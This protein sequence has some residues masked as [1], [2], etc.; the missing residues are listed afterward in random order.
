MCR[1]QIRGDAF[2]RAP[3]RIA[4][5]SV[6]PPRIRDAAA[7]KGRPHQATYLSNGF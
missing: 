4:K 1:R 6:R 7:R 3:S 5:R 2:D